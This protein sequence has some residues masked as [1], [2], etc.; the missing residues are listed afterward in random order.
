[1]ASFH[2][3]DRLVRFLSPSW[4]LRH[5]VSFNAREKQ[6]VETC[7]GIANAVWLAGGVAAVVVVVAAATEPKAAPVIPGIDCRLQRRNC[8]RQASSRRHRVVLVV[9]V[10]K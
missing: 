7:F 5:Y 6:E 9:V 4:A 1:M 2:T 10:H 8:R 3:S